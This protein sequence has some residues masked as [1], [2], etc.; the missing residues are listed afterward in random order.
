[1]AVS[2]NKLPLKHDREMESESESERTLNRQQ[3]FVK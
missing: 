2:T 3:C 1:M